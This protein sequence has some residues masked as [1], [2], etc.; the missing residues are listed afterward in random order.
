MSGRSKE[1]EEECGGRS[2]GGLVVFL[3]MRM[4][5]KSEEEKRGNRALN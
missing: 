1:E 5:A 3:R 2:R 4:E